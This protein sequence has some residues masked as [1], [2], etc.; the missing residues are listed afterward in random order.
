MIG[1]LSQQVQRRFRVAEVYLFD[2]CSMKCGY[3]SLAESG[4]VVDA[5]QL[6]QFRDPARIRQLSAFFN[7]RTTDREGWNLM[8]TGGEPLLMPNL[9]LFCS[10]LFDAGNKAAFYTSLFVDK[11]QA[12][13]RFLE[14]CDPANV[15]YVMASLHPEAEAEE[16]AWFDKLKL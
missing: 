16:D 11:N 9:Q 14:A 7:S 3:C 4:R 13:F 15:D 5:S 10:E 12:N 8:F 1:P 2:T 6:A